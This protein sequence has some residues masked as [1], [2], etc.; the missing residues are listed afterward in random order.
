VVVPGQRGE[1][2]RVRYVLEVGVVLADEW[3]TERGG[4]QNERREVVVFVE[5]K[6]IT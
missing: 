2:F 6:A 1:K 3:F 4:Y 5:R